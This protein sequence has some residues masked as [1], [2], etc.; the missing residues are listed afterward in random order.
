MRW[1]R[2]LA[3][4]HLWL[5][6]PL[7]C[8]AVLIGLT[9]AVIVFREELQ[10]LARP[11]LNPGGSIPITADPDVVLA[12]VRAQFPGWSPLSI[13][14]PHDAT[15]Y[16]MIYM[17]EGPRVLE[18]YVNP[19][20]GATVGT[21]DPRSGWLGVVSSLHTN[22]RFGR[23]GR[24]A[25]GYGA[26]G[27]MMLALSGF[28]LILT[29]LRLLETPRWHYLMGTAGWFF[30]LALAFTG[31]YYTW[32]AAY[33]SMV[34]RMFERATPVP[35]PAM[36]VT[37]TRPLAQLIAIAQSSYP[38]QQIQRVPIPDARF[39]F[40]VVFREGRFAAFHE[41]SAVVLDPRTGAIL[42][43]QHLSQRPTGDWLLGW[44]SAFH[45]GV[46]GGRLVQL[47]W[48]LL[49]L[50][51]AGLGATGICMWLKRFF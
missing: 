35:L 11:D 17:I 22:L 19:Q 51:L 27:V 44:F 36:N 26:I 48:C 24:M 12:Q 8:Y 45:F 41:V 4:F 20:S 2:I 47:L 5:G 10:T 31:A 25:N 15:P 14:W 29:R 16:W 7:G 38:G 30:L 34:N 40:R 23:N 13:T 46:F 33:I 42:S 18:V 37:T 50:A 28:A 1:R 3:L 39:P 6:V 9:G 32:P 49:G 21:H 43:R